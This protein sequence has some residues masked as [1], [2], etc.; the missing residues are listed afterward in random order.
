MSNEADTEADAKTSDKAETGADTKAVD[1]DEVRTRR[2]GLRWT[3]RCLAALVRDV[4]GRE[5]GRGRSGGTIPKRRAAG[6]GRR[7]RG[8]CHR[9]E[10]GGHPSLIL[11]L[12]SSLQLVG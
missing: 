12:S 6:V 9:G 8:T 7:G 4:H 11:P 2:R 3:E 5:N 1:E 10:A